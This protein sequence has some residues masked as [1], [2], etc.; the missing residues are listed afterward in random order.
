[1]IN[2]YIELVVVL[3]ACAVV[4]VLLVVG[5]D[6][7]STSMGDESIQILNREID[8]FIDYCLSTA[9][10]LET[11]EK[12]RYTGQYDDLLNDKRELSIAKTKHMLIEHSNEI[13]VKLSGKRNMMLR[14]EEIIRALNIAVA[15][16]DNILNPEVKK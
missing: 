15:A 2:E 16:C 11:Y 4:A 14:R 3:V 6:M 10:S 1:M 13:L 12:R 7:W 9:S 5:K 8:T